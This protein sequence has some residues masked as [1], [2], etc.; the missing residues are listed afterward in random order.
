[1]FNIVQVSDGAIVSVYEN[2]RD[3][4]I[5]AGALNESYREAGNAERVRVARVAAADDSWKLREQ[6]RFDDGTYK[7]L[8]WASYVWANPDHFAHVSN[9]DDNLVAY[10]RDDA[11]GLADKQLRVRPGR[12][13]EQHYSDVLSQDDIRHWCA[14]FDRDQGRGELLFTDTADGIQSVYENGPSSCMSDPAENY[15]S[16]IHPTRVYG[17]GDLGVAYM[18]EGERVT[19]RAL[20]WVER[21]IYGRMYGDENRIEALLKEEGF[22]RGDCAAAWEGARLLRVEQRDCFAAPYLDHPMDSVSDNGDYLI[23]SA[24]GDICCRNT[25]GLSVPICTCDNCGDPM[26]QSESHRIGDD[27]WC[28]GCV[29]NYC[30]WCSG[31][32]GYCLQDEYA[33]RSNDD[34][35]LC[36]HCAQHLTRCESCE[37]L[38]EDTIETVE[39]EQY[40]Q[41]CASNELSLTACE[42]Y[43]RDTD[44]CKCP[45]CED[46]RHQF[47]MEI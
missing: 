1:M 15:D 3:A 27:Y 41:D 18:K 10:T 43:A 11:A 20:V 34:E 21:K 13:L 46:A 19:A 5:V 17:A 47:E 28:E 26:D 8:P 29:D 36:D 16:E 4:A 38:C 23:I 33:G 25:E 9:V 2:G 35:S 14:V 12:Y 37:Y 31:C 40:C 42:E 39:H 24:Y 6:A 32:E 7:R 22:K 44:N 45:V 30:F